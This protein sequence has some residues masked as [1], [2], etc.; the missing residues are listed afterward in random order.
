MQ[1]HGQGRVPSYCQRAQQE[2]DLCPLSISNFLL[3]PPK[4]L[5]AGKVTGN[6]A[7]QGKATSVEGGVNRN[8]P[9]QQVSDS[10]ESPKAMQDPK[11]KQK[12]CTRLVHALTQGKTYLPLCS[13]CICQSSIKKYEKKS[14]LDK[15]IY[16]FEIL[17]CRSYQNTKQSQSALWQ[18][19]QKWWLTAIRGKSTSKPPRTIQFPGAFTKP[20]P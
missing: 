19:L 10:T 9:F 8:T 15:S 7:L 11:L 17:Y 12:G 20:F 18:M 2:N 4:L 13:M 3:N 14:I 1:S 16:S 6:C 5:L